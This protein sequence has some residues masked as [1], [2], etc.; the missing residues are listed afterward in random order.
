[1]PPAPKV[2][3]LIPTYNYAR[4]L[5]EAI[6][7]VLAQDFGDFELVISDDASADNSAE[8]IRS[9][10]ARDSRIRAHCQAENRGMAANWNWCLGEARGEYVKYL[11]GDDRLVSNQALGRL[12]GLLD[13][14]PSATLAVSGRLILDEQSRAVEIW[15]ELGPAGLKSGR[16]VIVQC[17]R[18]DR[19]LIGEPSA[20]LFRR[21]AGLRGFDPAWRQL[22]DQEMWFHLLS[23]GNLV[24]DPEPLCAFRQHGAQQ[25][26]VNRDS[27]LSSEESLVMLARYLDDFAATVNLPLDS[28]A[29]RRLLFNYLYYSRKNSRKDAARTPAV[30]AAE[31]R[32]M[33]QLTPRWYARCLAWHRV[34][35]PLINLARRLRPPAQPG[36]RPVPAAAT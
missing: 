17:L 15:D 9:Y 33:A 10:A 24:Y 1:V 34:T 20:V 22:I 35:K 7:S 3:V 19:N 4:F 23:G 32:L 31:D 27:H 13:A 25:T 8:I 11:F 16:E 6:D 18:R 30:V 28:F 2:S 21:A 12:A 29:I 14:E 5:P 36:R 26:V